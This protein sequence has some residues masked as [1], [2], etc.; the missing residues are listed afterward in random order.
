MAAPPVPSSNSSEVDYSDMPALEPM[1]DAIDGG[2]RPAI[3]SD[4]RLTRVEQYLVLTVDG[5]RVRVTCMM[6]EV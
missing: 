3:N 5:E 1:G 4:A 6:P 2:Q